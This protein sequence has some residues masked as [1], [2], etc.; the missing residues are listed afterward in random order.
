MAKSLG[1]VD[2]RQLLFYKRQYTCSKKF[3]FT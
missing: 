2:M 3:Y 1:Y